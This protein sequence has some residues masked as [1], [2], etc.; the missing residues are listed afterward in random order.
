MYQKIFEA[1]APGNEPK[2]SPSGTGKKK[3]LGRSDGYTI[4]THV[5]VFC[6]V[7]LRLFDIGVYGKIVTDD[8]VS[9]RRYVRMFLK[10]VFLF[11]THAVLSRPILQNVILCA[12]VT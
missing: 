1:P 2:S 12:H 4:V 9:V 7:R 8:G 3:S 11:Y 5:W 6:S 10:T